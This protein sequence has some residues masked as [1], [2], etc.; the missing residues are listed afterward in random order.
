MKINKVIISGL[1][2]SSSIGNTIQVFENNLF[3]GVSGIHGEPSYPKKVA[4]IPKG[5][6]QEE[7]S[8]SKMVHYTGQAIQQALLNAAL[9]E[10]DLVNSKSGLILGTFLGQ[11]GIL[12]SKQE[13][14]NLHAD[15]SKFAQQLA[16]K[17]KI[18]HDL[19]ILNACSSSA[20]AISMGADLIRCGF[21]DFAIVGGFEFL[22]EFVFSGMSGLRTIADEIKPFHPE[23]GG[24]VIGEG[25]GILVLEAESAAVRERTNIYAEIRG[26]A[27]TNDAYHILRPRENGEGIEDAMRKSL[28]DG[29][30]GTSELDYI[31][32][33]GTGTVLN[34]LA[35]SNALKS[36]FQNELP[37]I[38]ITSNKPNFGHTLGAAGA[39]EAISCVLSIRNQ[40]VPHTLN[41][42]KGDAIENL[43]LVTNNPLKRNIQ[44]IISNSIGFGGTN[45]S[46][47]ISKYKPLPVSPKRVPEIQFQRKIIDKEQ[48]DL[49]DEVRK[50]HIEREISERLLSKIFSEN[51]Y[52]LSNKNPKELGLFYL[53]NTTCSHRAKKYYAQ[54][55]NSTKR[56]PSPSIFAAS[57]PS[58]H[59]GNL[60]I[61]YNIRG[62][63]LPIAYC[64][65]P[66][67]FEFYVHSILALNKIKVAI[68]IEYQELQEQIKASISLAE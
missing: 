64:D 61:K 44:T 3:G 18:K 36:V 65:D 11:N 66:S 27:I 53:S 30:I 24:T 33:H 49:S 52:G 60:A 32:L 55:T 43:P 23:R 12:N 56:K 25:V 29:T 48:V 20:S 46:L 41:V 35:E 31:N 57:F 62:V 15:Y 58:A 19:T 40:K 4:V 16:K 13:N 63:V 39:I 17:F 34:D 14:N 7:C 10:A 51:K 6:N 28:A 2:I 50:E 5:N 68:I 1:G 47:V 26:S 67:L 21:L 54:L 38:S 9:Q 22:G 59:T 45:A 8:K 42:N 37:N